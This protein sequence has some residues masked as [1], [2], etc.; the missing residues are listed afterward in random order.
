MK[1][2]QHAVKCKLIV[3]P[4]VVQELKATMREFSKACNLIAEIG[5]N[6]KLHRR[7]D[8]HHVTYN[9]V[10]EQTNLPS[11][12]AIN[13]IA[14]VAEQFTR[15]RNKQHKFKQLSS[16]RYDA[17]TLTF[18][19]DFHEATLTI[20]PKGRVSGELQ[21]PAAMREKLRTW[22]IGSADL[23]HR[24]GQFYLH[25]SINTDAPEVPKPTGSLGIDLGVKRVAVTSDNTFHTAKFIRHKKRCFQKTRSELQ[26]NGSRTSKRVLRRVSGRELRFVADSNHCISKKIVAHAK[27]NNQRIV[28]EDLSGIRGRA[29]RF[30]TRHLHGWS[31]AQLRV[32][33]EYKAK[34]AG[35]EVATVDPAYTSKGCSRCLHIGS[36]SSQSNFNCAH[37]G[38]RLN[39]D[40]NGARSVAVRYDLMATGGYFCTLEVSQPAQSVLTGETQAV[41]FT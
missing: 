4:N 29:K 6:Q 11:Q 32:F 36:R 19:R 15:K 9:Q 37:C 20:C 24:H 33:V 7:F 34:A 12:H 16:V 27:A 35:V 1:K 22:K 41:S 26:A 21:M 23:I 40:I 2:V 17:R 25:I 28:L 30:M 38:L 39:A 31:F 13:A 14:K 5:F 18:K 10:R 8:L 3:T